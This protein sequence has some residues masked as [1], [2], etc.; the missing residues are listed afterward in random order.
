MTI[1]LQVL[2]VAL[3]SVSMNAAAQV[4]LKIATSRPEIGPTAA[5]KLVGSLISVPGVA[6]LAIYALSILSWVW[7][8]SKLPVSQAYPFISIGFVLVAA[9]G[10]LF[11]N[12][13]LH[14]SAYLGIF[15]IAIGLYLVARG[16]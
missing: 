12:E 2:M 5:E 7:V 3:V 10:H 16:R 8:L 11:L 15:L 4:L 9:F 6:A 1:S 14:W 13:R